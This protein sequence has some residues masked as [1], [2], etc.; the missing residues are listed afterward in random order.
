[1]FT[2]YRR[3]TKE[4]RFTSAGNRKCKCPIWIDGRIAGKRVRKALKTRSWEAAHTLLRK[5]ENEGVP[6]RISVKEAL[7][8]F[9]KYLRARNLRAP[10]VYKYE[11]LEKELNEEFSG[12]LDGISVQD[13]RRYQN[14][15]KVCPQSR[16]NKLARLKR[17]FRWFLESG[18]MSF[19]P[20]KSLEP[21][22]FM[23]K[24]AV[25]F[26]PEELEKIMWAIEVY[27]DNPPG[28]QNLIKAFVLILRYTGLRIG[29]V[30][31]LR[32]EN[33]DERK[34]KLFLRTA[35]T[36]TAVWCHLNRKCSILLPR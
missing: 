29:D 13:L 6:S 27:P 31:S 5:W 28:R 24:P 14:S 36:G 33:I 32:W 3:H 10:S 1:M 11:L 34:G 16:A 12:G 8:E 26:T 18:Y 25:P 20:A 30:T 2:A 19:N 23:K 4:C 22:I 15:W 21:P 17:V 9:M 7:E 35:K